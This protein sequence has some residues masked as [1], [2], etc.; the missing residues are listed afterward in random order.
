MSSLDTSYKR[1]IQRLIFDLPSQRLPLETIMIC[2]VGSLN[3]F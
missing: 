1:I 2:M 3:Q